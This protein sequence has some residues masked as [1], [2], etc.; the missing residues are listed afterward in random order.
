MLFMATFFILLPASAQA[1]KEQTPTVTF[2]SGVSNVRVDAQVV[3]GTNVVKDLTQDDFVVSDEKQPQ[4]ILYFGRDAEPVSLLL[5]L[6][7]SGSMKKYVDQVAS[8]ARESLRYMKPGDKVAVMVFSKGSLVRRDFTEDLDVVAREIRN[9]NWE[10][11][12]GSGTAIND[13]LLDAAKY[14]REKADE[15]GRRS[16][17]I[18]TDNLGLNYKSPDAKV[19]QRLY[20]ADTVLNAMVV[21]R[22]ERPVP[23]RPGAYT[24]PDFTPPDVF[25]IADETGGEAIRAERAAAI[26][27]EMI[28][29]IRTR[30]SLQ[31]RAPENAITGFRSISV[32]LT[33][34]A[35][36]RHPNAE[37]RARKGY[38]IAR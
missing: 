23:P 3:E 33:Q 29:R 5:L 37:V 15:T 17:L 32:E 36:S 31:Y 16:I 12:L 7:V 8:V 24:N 4:K 25:H 9:A 35:K 19:I 38:Y 10:D 2:R 21:G 11:R 28:E 18:L 14:I 1:P 27:P 26:F 13:A 30:Y 20:E 6:D 22:G 34:L